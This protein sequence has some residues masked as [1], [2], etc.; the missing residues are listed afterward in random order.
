MLAWIYERQER[1][2]D[3]LNA[4]ETAVRLGGDS[5]TSACEIAFLHA[6]LGDPQRAREILAKDRDQFSTP[7]S[8]GKQSGETLSQPRRA[9]EVERVARRGI[10]GP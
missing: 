5:P 3:A 1:Y 10:R 6:R 9:R 4:M 2:P 8:G 7:A